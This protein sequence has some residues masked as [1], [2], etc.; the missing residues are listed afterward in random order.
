MEVIAESLVSNSLLA[1]NTRTGRCCRDLVGSD[2]IWNCT[3]LQDDKLELC[4]IVWMY[5]VLGRLTNEATLASTSCT[6]TLHRIASGSNNII[7]LRELHNI[8]IV[9]IL[10]E[11]LGF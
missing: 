11:G 8:C 6:V 7:Q 10:K 5:P 3:Y 1:L 2:L 4:D 9:I